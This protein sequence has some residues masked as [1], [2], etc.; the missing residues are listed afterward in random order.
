MSLRVCLI[1]YGRM[2]KSIESIL[3]EYDCT[4]HHIIRR[5]ADW[6]NSK[7]SEC[8]VAIDF[9]LP[10][11]AK[12][13]ILHC[14]R[15]GIPVVSGTTGWLQQIDEV[16]ESL[17]AFPSSTFLYGSN[18]SLGMN[19][20]FRI[21]EFTSKIMKADPSYSLEMKEIHHT[22]KLDAPSGTAITLAEDIIN[23]RADKSKWV[24]GSS[25]QKDTI[26]IISERTVD[27]P[28][29]HIISYE[30][31]VDLI[32]IEHVAKSRMGFARGAILAAKWLKDK[33]G[34]FTISD[35]VDDLL[36]NTL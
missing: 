28:G 25:S 10:K 27:V 18:F 14:I 33:N 3:G 6:A 35:Y 30:N 8:E 29:T 7:V 32:Q 36:K 34:F 1:G 21:N 22:K 26:G 5:E 16:K 24:N 23:S 9:S 19:L 4:A 12:D 15:L 31:D 2:G 20:F 17:K 11:T 13:N